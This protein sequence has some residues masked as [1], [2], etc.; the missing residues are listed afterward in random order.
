M[1]K[2]WVAACSALVLYG[3]DG[4]SDPVTC[5][6]WIPPS[7]TVTVRDS[8]SGANITNLSTLVLRNAAGVV[9]ST[10]LFVP[11]PDETVVSTSLGAGATG[12]F[13]LTVRRMGYQSWTKSGIVVENGECG[14]RTANVTA[15]LRPVT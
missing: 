4:L 2:T 14:A 5:P 10:S 1:K 3:C 12:T 8:V 6:D 9:D 13:S 11:A 7:V 15:R